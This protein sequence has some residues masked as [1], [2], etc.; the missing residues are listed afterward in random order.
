MLK[1]KPTYSEVETTLRYDKRIRRVLYKYIGTIEEIARADISNEYKFVKNL[2]I[3]RNCKQK[4]TFSYLSLLTFKKLFDVYKD[5]KNELDYKSFKM[6]NFDKKVSKLILL[7][8][9]VSHNRFLLSKLNISD[10]ENLVEFLPTEIA[11][12]FLVDLAKTS[13]E[14]LEQKFKTQA[15]WT[16]PQEVVIKI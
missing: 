13:K 16:L 2:P 5:V 9:K 12:S 8:N 14:K 7:R 15:Q 10:I 3:K 1:R 4:R 6:T 11:N